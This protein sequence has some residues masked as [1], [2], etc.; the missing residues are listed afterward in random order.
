MSIKGS[1]TEQLI[2]RCAWSRYNNPSKLVKWVLACQDNKGDSQTTINS[3]IEFF[4]KLHMNYLTYAKSP[5][6]IPFDSV[7]IAPQN[8]SGFV[9]RI[10]EEEIKANAERKE[11]A[12]DWREVT[13]SEIL[14]HFGSNSS[15]KYKREWIVRGSPVEAEVRKYPSVAKGGNK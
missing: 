11:I 6:S 3:R 2:T 10:G 15:T 7:V 14:K 9:T 12:S 4:A 13:Q 1:T 8:T 5:V